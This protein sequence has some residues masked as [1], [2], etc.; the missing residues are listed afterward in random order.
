MPSTFTVIPSIY[1]QAV[2]ECSKTNGSHVTTQ[3]MWDLR[4]WQWCS[5]DMVSVR[6]QSDSS[7][8]SSILK[9][10]HSSKVSP[11]LLNLGNEGSTF[12][13]M[14]GSHYLVTKYHAAD[15]WYPQ[16]RECPQIWGLRSSVAED[17]SLMGWDSMSNKWFKPMWDTE[18]HSSNDT[19]S[20]T[21]W[22][23]TYPLCRNLLY[24]MTVWSDTCWAVNFIGPS[25][26]I[27]AT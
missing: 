12:L 21:R 26:N 24:G 4:F 14:F 11:D 25:Q 16:H 27:Q 13:A 19:P 17:S 5:L 23:D 15:E 3:R 9:A 8:F 20:H 1:N 18:N 22:H 6:R 10:V 2:V 7:I